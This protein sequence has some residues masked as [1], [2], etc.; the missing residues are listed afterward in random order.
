M[1]QLRRKLLPVKNRSIA[2]LMALL[3]AGGLLASCGQ[4]EAEMRKI[5]VLAPYITHGWTA[6]IAYY[7]E[8]HCAEL[9]EEGKIDYMIYSSSNADEMTLQLADFIDWG[10]DAVAVFPQWT[11][12]DDAFQKAIDAGVVV[13]NFGVA[14]AANG[15]YFIAG[16]NYSIGVEGAKYIVD[17]IGTEGNVVILDVPDTG[18]VAQ[19]RKDGFLDTLAEIAPNITTQTYAT[20]FTREA[21]RSDMENILAANARI[22]AVFSMGDETS[23]GALH[24]IRDAGRSDIKAITGGGGGQEYFDV[25][26]KNTDIWIASATYSPVMVKMAIDMAVD[27]LDGK[28]VEQVVIIPTVIVDRTNV[29]E[30]L[31]PELPY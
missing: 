10:A 4:R 9:K 29:S 24:A 13:V 25:M 7:A 8:K 23:I 11:G 1:H 17:K 30:Y 22:D 21:G 12:M 26:L 20:N 31:D 5:G 18:S 16:D 15:I 6:G 19:L 27:I 3:A 2:A 14:I 28:E